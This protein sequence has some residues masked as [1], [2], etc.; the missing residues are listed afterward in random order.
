M[1]A[2]MTRALRGRRLRTA[3][4]IAG[5]ATSALLVVV[6]GAAFR[7][8]RTAMTDY[9]GQRSV[10]LWIAPA[11]SDNLI[12]G[13]FAAQIPLDLLDSMRIIPGV[14]RVDPLLKGFLSV[15]VPGPPDPDRTVTLLAIG[16]RTPDGLGGPPSV[17]EGVPPHGR[18]EIA[19]DRAAAFRLGVEVGDTVVLGRVRVVVTALT[20]GTNILATQFLFGDFDAAAAGLGSRHEA[21]LAL[22][23]LTPGTEAVVVRALE[24]AF[25]D[26]HVYPRAAFVRANEREVLAGFLPL[27]T[28]VA[29]LGIGTACVLVGLL[30]LSIVDERRGEI[31]V[32]MAI[33]AGDRR[34]RWAV[35][36]HAVTLLAFGIALGQILAVGLTVAID[37]ALPSIPLT[38]SPWDGLLVALA[39]GV[40]GVAASIVPA[41]QLGRVDVLEAFRT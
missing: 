26:L 3:V 4:A 19:L 36:T 1:I 21:S 40:A 27:L 32:L 33:G 13:S 29:A 28:L 41:A 24:T 35:V 17:A 25:P 14:A 37:R 9:A 11:G 34:I 31:A 2:L 5:I 7:G 8:V 30:V 10:D 20:R 39:F 16:Y 6:L 18:R 38:L 15:R 22:V 12:R 23:Q